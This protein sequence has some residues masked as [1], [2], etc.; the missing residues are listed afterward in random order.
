MLSPPSMTKSCGR[1]PQ[2]ASAAGA[3]AAAAAAAAPA[4]PAPTAS[5]AAPAPTATGA[6]KVD[7]LS[8]SARYDSQAPF[9]KESL[10]TK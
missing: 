10:L 5:A 1:L 9:P 2:P 7:A 8:D 6:C 3:A 4:A